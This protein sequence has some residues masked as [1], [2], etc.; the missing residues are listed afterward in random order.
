MSSMKDAAL[1]GLHPLAAV[2][3][4]RFFSSPRFS[5]AFVSARLVCTGITNRRH[6]V[7]YFRILISPRVDGRPG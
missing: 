2:A 6:S 1:A 7:G 4:R 3:D 5:R